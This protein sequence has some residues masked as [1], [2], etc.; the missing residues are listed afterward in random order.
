MP[1]SMRSLELS[2]ISFTGA[3]FW[4]ALP[5]ERPFAAAAEGSSLTVSSVKLF[6]APQ[7]HW[8]IHLGLS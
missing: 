2:L 5:A 3:G 7:M 4:Y 1:V 6:Q 8:P